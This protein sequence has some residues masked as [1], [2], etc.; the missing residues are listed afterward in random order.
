MKRQNMTSVAYPASSGGI[1]HVR[2]P[3][4]NITIAQFAGL[5]SRAILD[6]PVV[7]NTGLTG[8]YDFEIE[9]TPDETQFGGRIPPGPPDTQKPGLFLAIQQT[10]GLKL[11][12]TR[13]AVDAIVIDGVERP[14][15]N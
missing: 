8:R 11:E 9:W 4:H 5:L 10:L 12:A 13:G 3:A 1:D 15:D 2:L 14:A 7:D 6:R